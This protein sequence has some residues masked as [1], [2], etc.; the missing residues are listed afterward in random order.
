MHRPTPSPLN[1]PCR[2][3]PVDDLVGASVFAPAFAHQSVALL[4]QAIDLVLHPL[5][6][7]LRRHGADPFALKGLDFLPLAKD[8]P[9]HMLDFQPD[10]VE[11]HCKPRFGCLEQKG[12]IFA[13]YKLKPGPKIRRF[14]MAYSDLPDQ[15]S[16]PMN[17]YQSTTLRQ[18][19]IEAYQP[20]LFAD[21]LTSKEAARRIEALKREIA[22]ANSF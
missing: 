12:N 16:A 18:L 17:E 14:S 7:G 22:L 9:P 1:A 8:L 10:M 3:G 2:G 15:V 13:S 5:E 4:A 19:S 6:Q 20:K 11:S 21:D